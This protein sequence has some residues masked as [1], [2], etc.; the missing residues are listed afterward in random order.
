MKNKVAFYTMVLW[1]FCI[2]FAQQTPQL[3]IS[4]GSVKLSAFTSIEYS[5][6]SLK[7]PDSE[8]F[9]YKGSKYL[10]DKWN[11]NVRFNVNE[12][13]YSIESNVNYNIWDRSLELK[14]AN[15]SV[16]K[17]DV[18]NFDYLSI[19]NRKFKSF[20]HEKEDAVFE[21]LAE[22]DEYTFLKKHSLEVRRLEPDPLMQRK[23]NV[24]FIKEEQYFI[25][26]EDDIIKPIKLKMKSLMTLFKNKESKIKE[27]IAS[28]DL[29][30]KKEEDVVKV[31]NYYNQLK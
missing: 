16:A 24:A 8:T 5:W 18:L 6:I 29:S 26:E 10:F 27:F 2:C 20:Y 21:L 1:S 4:K 9:R 13:E 19:N 3:R 15:D 25:L 30:Y 12:K 22:G 31:L 17:F 14:L 7:N 28:N 23:E 11:N